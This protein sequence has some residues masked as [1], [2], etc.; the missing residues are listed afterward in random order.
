[1]ET[2]N[3]LG[4]LSN[5]EDLAN[6]EF[7]PI[8]VRA[9]QRARALLPAEIGL[10]HEVAHDDMRVRGNAAL[11]EDV[12][13][14]ACIL[15]WQ[16]MGATRS[17]IVVEAAEVVMDEIVLN[18]DAETLQGGLPPRRYAHVSIGT[19]QR[20]PVGPLH[21]A[22][23]MPADGSRPPSAR[24]LKLIQM[25]EAVTGHKGTFSVFTDPA[26]GSAFDIYLPTV[27][28]LG[29]QAISGS[30]GAVSHV[31]Y[32][33]DYV[34]MRE[35][36]SEVLPDAGFRV[37]CFESGSEALQYIKSGKD[38]CDAVVTDYKLV[39]LNGIDLLRQV[40]QLRPDLPV[41][42]VSGY[43]DDALRARA[44]E[45][46]AAF[47]LSKSN[48]VDVLCQV[49]RQL[50]HVDPVSQPGSFTDWASL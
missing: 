46:G 10:V 1:M 36:V 4:D 20:M 37:S 17:N 21:I 28:P 48:D 45:H 2:I 5:A 35:L 25:R 38:V 31:I 12:F 11:L 29:R 39:D 22:M 33:D 7:V 8:L 26:L 40:K 19:S 44:A 9:L 13:A 18:K 42:I 43:A 32:V 27:L 3:L 50:L 30:G 34:G 49:L 14:S 16:S 24:R 23:P 6:Q 47:V 15:A 41:I